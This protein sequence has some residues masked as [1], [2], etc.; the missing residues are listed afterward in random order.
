MTAET[1]GDLKWGYSKDIAERIILAL[2]KAVAGYHKLP[3]GGWEMLHDEWEEFLADRLEIYA[4]ERTKE[5]REAYDEKVDGIL[6]HASERTKE[7]EADWL[8]RCSKVEDELGKLRSD[9]A[10]L[11]YDF[12]ELDTKY[13]ALVTYTR[14][15]KEL[16]NENRILKELNSGKLLAYDQMKEMLEQY[17][18][19]RSELEAENARL[20]EA[21]DNIRLCLSDKP[22]WD[23]LT[24]LIESALSSVEEK[25]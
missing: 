9:N 4:S 16:E 17:A 8:I 19:Q 13:K 3:D 5:L 12:D 15:R 24:R 7:L 20:R 25:P 6:G 2:Q 14:E 21:L 11:Q 1:T 22:E 23:F 18:I 10:L